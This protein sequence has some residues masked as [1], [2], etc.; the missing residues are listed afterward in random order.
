MDFAECKRR[1]IA[2]SQSE[3]RQDEVELFDSH[4]LPT[5]EEWADCTKEVIDAGEDVDNPHHLMGTYELRLAKRG[6]KTSLGLAAGGFKKK[7]QELA[8]DVGVPKE[9]IEDVVRLYSLLLTK[10]S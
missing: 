10:D 6:L 3:G 8:S 5:A 9:N 4:P 1:C 2:I 7:L